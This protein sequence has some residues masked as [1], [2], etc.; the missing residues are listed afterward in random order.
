MNT[1]FT[2]IN[3]NYVPNKYEFLFGFHKLSFSHPNNYISFIIK[4]FIWITKFKNG[5][6]TINGFKN[7]LKPYLVDL[8]YI[9]ETKKDTTMLTEWNTIFDVF[10]I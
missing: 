6:L 2:T 4:R 8:K 5:N 1:Y 10:A 3:V 9:F 7:H